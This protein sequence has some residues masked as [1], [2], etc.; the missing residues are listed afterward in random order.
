MIM[1]PLEAQI[2][3]FILLILFVSIMSLLIIFN[4]VNENIGNKREVR[5]FRGM[6]ISFMI[7]TIIDLRI[8]IGDGF[9]QMFPKY[10][11]Y[12]WVAVGFAVMTFS[13]YFWFM[14]VYAGFSLVYGEMGKK[15][16]PLRKIVLYVPLT[17]DLVFLFTPL[18]YYVFE[19]TDTVPFFKPGVM[20][21]L[22]MDYCYLIVATRMALFLWKRARTKA[23]RKRYKSQAIYILF[24]T[25]SGFIIGYFMNLPAIELCMQPVVIKIFVELQ[26]SQI[27]TD[28]LTKLYNRRRMTEYI[29]EEIGRC[30]S[31]KPLYIQMIDMDYFKS[32]NDILGHE[33]GDKALV[34]FS[35]IIKN[36]TSSRDA[37]AARW[38]GDEFVIAGKD[39]WLSEVFRRE[40]TEEL[41]KDKDLGY[42]LQISA[43]LYSCTDKDISCDELMALADEELYKD[44]EIRHKRSGN[45]VEQLMEKK[46]NNL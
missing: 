41:E 37:V 38:G 6:I 10:V 7:Y 39:P 35:G 19:L 12:I 44:K 26:D 23:D 20:L 4:K 30:S 40:L 24:F 2:K 34:A 45:F 27:Y 36:L 14:Y 15:R 1:I 42:T 11:V 18:S 33:E 9:Y 3:P 46:K 16:S 13:C 8:V 21:L 32:I 28:A 22:V 43:G 25:V 29:T 5:S 17:V 31:T